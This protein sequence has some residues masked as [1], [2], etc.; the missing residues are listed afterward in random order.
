MTC[1]RCGKVRIIL[2]VQMYRSDEEICCHKEYLVMC[3][4]W[5]FGLGAMRLVST[6]N[7][8]HMMVS[9]GEYY[10]LYNSKPQV[11][12]QGRRVRGTHVARIATSSLVAY[13][14]VAT[15]YLLSRHA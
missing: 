2:Y 14:K 5:A 1:V 3:Y 15:R 13:K 10:V 7:L 12:H 4:G 9:C 8:R 6:S 11:Q